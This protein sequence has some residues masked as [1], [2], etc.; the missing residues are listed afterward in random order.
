MWLFAYNARMDDGRLSRGQ[1]S[2][3]GLFGIV[4]AFAVAMTMS[5]FVGYVA[6]ILLVGWYTALCFCRTRRSI[7]LVFSLLFVGI[8]ALGIFAIIRTMI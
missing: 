8:C 7:L 5:R 6:S 4:A 2:V 3:L 1:L